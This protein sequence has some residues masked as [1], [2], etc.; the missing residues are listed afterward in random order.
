MLDTVISTGGHQYVYIRLTENKN[1][2]QDYSNL[3]VELIYCFH[4]SF[5]TRADWRA[6]RNNKDLTPCLRA[7]NNVKNW[8]IDLRS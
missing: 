7:P 2:P 3:S 8:I 5:N 4:C 6:M 1:E